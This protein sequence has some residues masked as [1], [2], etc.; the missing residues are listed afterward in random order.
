MQNTDSPDTIYGCP[1]VEQRLGLCDL[2]G[3]LEVDGEGDFLRAAEGGGAE[4]GSASD[5]GADGRAFAATEECAHQGSCACA[6]AGA[7]QGRSSFGG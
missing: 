3:H 5:D 7:D 6:K 2:D 1:H 4:A